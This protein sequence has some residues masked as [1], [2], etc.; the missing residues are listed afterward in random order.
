MQAALKGAPR[1]RLH[2]H[3]ADGVADRGA[4]PA[5]VHGRRGRPAVPRVRGHAGDHDPD[6]GGGLADAGADDVGALAEARTATSTASGDRRSACQRGFDRV[7]AALRPR[8]AT[9]CWRARALTLLVALGTLVADGA[10]LHRDPQGPVPDAGH[11]PAAGAHR[12]GA[13]GRRTRAWPSCSRRR[14]GACSTTRRSRASR[15]F[16]GV[17]AANN[18]MLHTGRMLIN[19]KADRAAPQAEMME[20]LRERVQQ[21]AGV[22][23]YLQPTQDLTI[24][25][26]SGPTAVPRRRSKAP[27]PRPSTQ[28]ARRLVAAAAASRQRCATSITDAG[29]Q[30]LAAVRRRSTAT[31]RRAWASPPR[32]STTRCTAPSA[33]ASSRPSSPRPTSTA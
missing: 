27:T 32:R 25:A 2:H 4:D 18:T 14:R 23:L 26:E 22:T 5:A 1:D 9:G 17:D 30:G 33:S 7:I 19:L 31:P 28:W 10:A 8:A 16:V 12:G 3:L 21:V 15:S 29:A 11:R 20:R 24:D 6:L 13:V